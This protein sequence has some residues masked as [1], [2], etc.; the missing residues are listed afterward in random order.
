MSDCSHYEVRN[1]FDVASLEF[2]KGEWRCSLCG[3]RFVPE[4][5]THGVNVEKVLNDRDA[6]RAAGDALVEQLESTSRGS[7]GEFCA[8]PWETCRVGDCVQARAAL[9]QWRKATKS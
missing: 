7:H 8:G 5:A 6:L 1:G 4:S 9:E 2:L 3:A